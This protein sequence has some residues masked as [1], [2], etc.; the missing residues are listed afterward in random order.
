MA[1]I[2]NDLIDSDSDSEIDTAIGH[3]E[4]ES[5]E[6]LPVDLVAPSPVIVQLDDEPESST[7]A[8]AS[9]QPRPSTSKEAQCPMCF[10]MF[11]MEHIQE[12]ADACSP[13][14]MELEQPADLSECG[15]SADIEESAVQVAELD[16]SQYKSL[17]KKKI[18]ECATCLSTNVKRINVRRRFLWE[19]FKAARKSKI[20]PLSNLK[21]V[22]VG[23]PSIHDGGPKR[24]LFCGKF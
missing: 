19:D 2:F 8:Q 20:G 12:H 9:Q 4:Q 6:T 5:P 22:F 18:G 7:G 21:V 1:S 17:L 10:Q 23:E 16:M 15:N 13:W 24:E 3:M 14:A 11:P